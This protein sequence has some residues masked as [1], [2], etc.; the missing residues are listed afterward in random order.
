MAKKCKYCGAEM[1]DSAIICPECDKPVAGAEILLAKQ[2]SD[3]KRRLVISIVA[4]ACIVLIVLVVVVVNVSKKNSQ[5]SKT[6][7]EAIDLNLAS[8][9]DDKPDE[10]LKSYPEFLRGYM[11][12]TLGYLTENGFEEYLEL[13]SNE[14]IRVYGS[15]VSISYE[16]LSKT[17]MEQDDID[18]YMSK[19]FEY[20]PEYTEDDYNIQDAYQI[21]L[22]IT[23]NGSVS[24]QD[25][26][27][28]VMVVQVD[29]YWYTM[30]YINL[31][32]Q[33][34]D[35]QYQTIEQ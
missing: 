12:E 28:S 3:K 2:K 16:M 31:I 10:Y 8:M 18:E 17:H 20:L 14:L 29:G 6:Y 22:N 13:M 23:A 9:V 19:I 27:T 21:T 35:S 15:D 11:Q 30:N 34:T 32:S 24:K 1:S 5:G 25:M 33:G 7:V 26:T 4:I